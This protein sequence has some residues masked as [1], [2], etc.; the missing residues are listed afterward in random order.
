MAGARRAWGGPLGGLCCTYT[1][2]QAMCCALLKLPSSILGKMRYN[3]NEVY[4]AH[5]PN[6][7]STI[8]EDSQQ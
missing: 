6:G 7:A 1:G 4:A 8:R 2:T 5:L 3:R